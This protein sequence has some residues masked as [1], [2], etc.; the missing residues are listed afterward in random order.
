MQMMRFFLKIYFNHVTS[1]EYVNAE[2]TAPQQVML[3]LSVSFVCQHVKD[4]SCIEHSA[5]CQYV[6]PVS[7]QHC[8]S[9]SR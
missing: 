6:K 1:L 9:N 2:A 5:A 3:M 8:G 7:I 4:D